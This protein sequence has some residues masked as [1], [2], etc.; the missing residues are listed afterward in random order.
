MDVAS[1]K[2]HPL[3]LLLPPLG[4]EE[5]E[6]LKQS[7]KA[8]G[9]LPRHKLLL[10]EGQ[11][12]D[13]RN[14]HEIAIEEGIDRIPF[15]H[16][17][18]TKK[19]AELYVIFEHLGRRSF[20]KT[21]RAALIEKHRKDLGLTIVQAA[22]KAGVS[23]SLQQKT[24]SASKRDETFS[25]KAVAG[26]I[27]INDAVRQ[28]EKDV[29]ERAT[30]EA[31][32][33]AAVWETAEVMEAA[34]HELVEWASRTLDPLLGRPGAEVLCM[35]LTRKKRDATG[36]EKIGLSLIEAM[37]QTLRASRPKKMCGDCNGEKCQACMNLGYVTAGMNAG[38]KAKK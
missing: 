35:S 13:G 12:L 33:F 28:M 27:T 7:M 37:I 20:T 10:F 34:E 25:D 26:Q 30:D 1:L 17:E 23:V 6:V 29:P 16:F 5:R 4:G 32:P 15:E 21:Q 38:R 9:F 24:S 11:I 31:D 3:C 14:R 36:K 2:P 22:K 8:Q 18:G 19:D